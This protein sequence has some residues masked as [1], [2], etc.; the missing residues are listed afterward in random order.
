MT[1]MKTGVSRMPCDSI[2]FT[3]LWRKELALLSLINYRE[4]ESRV[5]YVPLVKLELQSPESPF[6]GASACLAEASRWSMWS[7]SVALCR[8]SWSAVGTDSRGDLTEARLAPALL[9]ILSFFPAAYPAAHLWPE[10]HVRGPDCKPLRLQL[11]Q[12]K[13]SSPPDFQTVLS[14]WGPPTP[15]LASQMD[16]VVTSLIPPPLLPQV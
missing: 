6:L 10:A 1:K 7:S 5:S 14:H 2:H 13:G 12:S 9:C 16:C 4:P 3:P 11:S 8:S 15:P